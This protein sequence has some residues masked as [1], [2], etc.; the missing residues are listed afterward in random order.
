MNEIESAIAL[1]KKLSDMKSGED[2]SKY[3]CEKYFYRDLLT[4]IE[5]LQAQAERDNPQAL[6]LE[7]LKQ[8]DGKPVYVVFG[9]HLP[10]PNGEQWLIAE[11]VPMP[12]NAFARF[13]GARSMYRSADFDSYGKE[14]IA[15]DHEPKEQVK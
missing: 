6:T 7:Q 14:W 15:Y 13:Y 8:R 3:I 2:C 9:I 12:N 10:C 5:A 11:I 4:A 1:I